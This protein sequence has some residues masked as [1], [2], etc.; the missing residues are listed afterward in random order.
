ML[1]GILAMVEASS[2][3]LAISYGDNRLHDQLQHQEIARAVQGGA[4]GCNGAT[5]MSNWV[6]V[7]RFW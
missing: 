2:A 6:E 1:Q 3:A 7:H 5:C 4:Q